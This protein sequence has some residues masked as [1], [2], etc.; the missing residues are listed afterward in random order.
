M[1]FLP[2]VPAEGPEGILYL[3]MQRLPFLLSLCLLLL[4][5]ERNISFH[6]P[7]SILFSVILVVSFIT[8]SETIT[9]VCRGL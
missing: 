5:L 3:K 8:L 4:L 9:D 7:L 2:Y 6:Y 1:S